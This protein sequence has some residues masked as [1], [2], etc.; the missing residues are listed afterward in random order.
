MSA[1]IFA[2]SSVLVII[3]MLSAWTP[4]NSP[5]VLGV[6]GRY[7][8]PLLPLIIPI[9]YTDKLSGKEIIERYALFGAVS[10]GFYTAI[11]ALGTA[12]IQ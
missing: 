7:F 9:A 2:G 10:L 12:A 4:N 3:S 8:L 11:S 6:Q 1:A 5:V